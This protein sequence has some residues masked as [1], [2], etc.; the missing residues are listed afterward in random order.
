MKTIVAWNAHITRCIQCG[1][2]YDAIKCFKKMKDN[3]IS[4]NV[5]TF[6]CILKAYGIVGSLSCGKHIHDEIMNGG[7]WGKDV[8]L[9]NAL[10][11]MY[12]K[13][14]N[15]SKAREVLHERLIRNVVSWNGMMGR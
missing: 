9:G 10:I 8:I 13:C 5:V 3:G 1:Q 11:N 6:T 2:A 14:D 15:L 12:G 4:P 7:Y